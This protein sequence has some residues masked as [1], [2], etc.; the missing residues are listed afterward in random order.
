MR[1]IVTGGLGFIGSAVI[2]HLMAETDH[3]VLNLDNHGYAA[4]PDAVAMCVGNPRYGF[5]QADIRDHAALASIFARFQPDA[6]L[7]LA[8]ETHVDR[9]IDKPDAFIETNVNGTHALL[10]AS[11][12]HWRT[13]SGGARDGFRFH[14]VSTD[15]VFGSL[16]RDGLFAETSRYDP[17]SPYSA[18]KAAADHL[19][20]AWHRTFGLPV[21]LSNCSNNYGPYQFPEK[22]IPL[23]IIKGLAEAPLPV[24]GRGAQIRDWLHVEDHA[25]ALYAV[26]TRGRP[27][28]SYN[29]GARSERTNLQVV[30]AICEL[31]D[32]LSPRAS[33]K[34]H[35]DLIA[36]VVDRPGHD[37]RYAIDP[38]K[39][40]GELG[41][42]PRYAFADGL[43]RT[44]EWYLRNKSVWRRIHNSV[45][46]GERLG[47]D[48]GRA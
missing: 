37:F 41:W 30:E 22:L 18:S 1:L 8:A 40:E 13:R 25:R 28:E 20:R 39:I 48:N 44:V 38:T 11:L 14:H 45:Y 26:L 9:S 15:E 36:F 47:L 7:H 16:G 23:M 31:L 43:R 10:A 21:L 35:R 3:T 27:G 17:S 19:V 4:N 34:P 46:G 2:R 24:Y 5:V 33:G 12:A 29:V 42:S 32:E 6:I